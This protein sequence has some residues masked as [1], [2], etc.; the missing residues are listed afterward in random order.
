LK[1]IEEKKM[2]KKTRLIEGYQPI[3]AKQNDGYQPTANV[4]PVEANMPIPAPVIIIPVTPPKG[5]TG[6]TVLKK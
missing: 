1:R 3:T 6:E 5:G 4:Q 2:D